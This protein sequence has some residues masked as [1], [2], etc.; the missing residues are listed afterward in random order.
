MVTR[1]KRRLDNSAASYEN[2]QGEPLPCRSR[3]ISI[4]YCGD[5]GQNQ[6]LCRSEFQPSY[7]DK[8]IARTDVSI[9]FT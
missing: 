7:F 3:T 4:T 5:L 2:L 8:N 1:C 6:H 9:E